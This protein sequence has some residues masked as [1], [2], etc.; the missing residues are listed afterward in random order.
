MRGR[1]LLR[2]VCALVLACALLV[3]ARRASAG[4]THYWTWKRAPTT[5]ELGP[6]L[7]EMM[8][9]VDARRD[10]LADMQERTGKDAVFRISMPFGETGELPAIAFNGI[11]DLAHETFSFPLAAFAGEPKFSFVKTQWKPYDEVATACLIVARDHF[12][13]DVLEIS[14]DGEWGSEWDP[15]RKLYEEVLGRTAVN[16]LGAW[17]ASDEA[18]PPIEQDAGSPRRNL[19]ISIFFFGALVLVII[20]ANRR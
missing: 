6:C 15:G 18:P 7:D 20:L 8:R 4:Y 14:S 12:R 5:A 16:P 11:G 17:S 1:G 9:I 2:T 19:I 3:V 10:I 13:E